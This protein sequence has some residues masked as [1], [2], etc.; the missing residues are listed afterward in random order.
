[1]NDFCVRLYALREDQS[2]RHRGALLGSI[3]ATA[4]HL[5][6]ADRTRMS[7]LAGMPS[8]GGGI[9]ESVSLYDDWDELKHE[10][11]AFDTVV[12]DWAD[13]LDPKWLA[14]EIAY[15]SRANKSHLPKPQ[16]VLGQHILNHQTHHPRQ[17]P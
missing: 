17:M 3:H 14:G 4:N 9:P 5:L 10:R 7:R 13:R 12:I 2:L 15:Y 8:P 16:W 11:K 6:W 1:M